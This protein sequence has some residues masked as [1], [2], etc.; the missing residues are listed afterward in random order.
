MTLTRTT[1]VGVFQTRQ[2]AE[3]AVAELQMAGFENQ[4]IGL[5]GKNNFD[6]VVRHNSSVDHT[7]EAMAVGAAA[8][9]TA[10]AAVGAGILAGII[11]VIGPVLAIGTLGT[12]LLNAAGGAALAGIA[13]ALIGWGIP[14]DDAEY[15]ESE[16]ASGRY[17]VTVD[18]ADG[19]DLAES[20]FDRNGGSMRTPSTTPTEVI[21]IM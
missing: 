16:V 5:I 8:G 18:D 6:R 17:L 7:N 2:E 11:P 12:L 14:E 20:I 4:H 13:G 21:P 1:A 9:A 3:R 19:D 10:G 15:F